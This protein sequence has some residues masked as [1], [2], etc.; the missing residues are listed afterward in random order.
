M[1]DVGFIK[2]HIFPWELLKPVLRVA[3][4]PVLGEVLG[5]AMTYKKC[6][7]FGR[8]MEWISSWISSTFMMIYRKEKNSLKVPGGFSKLNNLQNTE[9]TQ[10]QNIIYVYVL[11][12]GFMFVSYHGTGDLTARTGLQELTGRRLLCFGLI[13]EVV[14][15]LLLINEIW[16][17]VAYQFWSFCNSSLPYFFFLL[18]SLPCLPFT[19]SSDL[20]SSFIS[21][22]VFLSHTAFHYFEGL[23]LT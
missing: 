5:S 9:K 6:S 13:A 15:S 7:Y 21:I 17:P 23:T 12:E 2:L 20:V 10:Q 16:A 19:K 11:E 3:S 1:G 4:E 22:D 18:C 14:S 8:R